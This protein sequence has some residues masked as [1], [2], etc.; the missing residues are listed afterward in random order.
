[1]KQLGI[2]FL[3]ASSLFLMS[4]FKP[5]KKESKA[6]TIAL[7]YIKAW[8]SHDWNKAR[9]LLAMMSMLPQTQLNL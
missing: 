7:A 2:L 5:I 4:A 9:K 6:V 8:S 3:L 1:M